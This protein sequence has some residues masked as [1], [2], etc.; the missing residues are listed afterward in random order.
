MTEEAMLRLRNRQWA[1]ALAECA[2]KRATTKSGR[3]SGNGGPQIASSTTRGL[4]IA[5]TQTNEQG[6]K[7]L[8]L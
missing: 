3:P 4:N 8:V 1:H 5:V 2:E 7:D 6:I